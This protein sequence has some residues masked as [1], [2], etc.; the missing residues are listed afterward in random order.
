LSEISFMIVDY[1][2][3]GFQKNIFQMNFVD[4][5]RRYGFTNPC[6]LSSNVMCSTEELSCFDGFLTNSL[7]CF[8][9]YARLFEVNL[10]IVFRC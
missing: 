4:L 7:A 10:E 1:Y 5:I 3:D 6:F 9:Q 2:F 8:S